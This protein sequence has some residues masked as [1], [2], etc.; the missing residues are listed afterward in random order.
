MESTTIIPIKVGDITSIIEKY[1]QTPD[2]IY[3]NNLLKAIP[4]LKQLI[5]NDKELRNSCSITTEMPIKL[6]NYTISSR[7]WECAQLAISKTIKGE[8]DYV[9]H[10][11]ID[12]VNDFTRAEKCRRTGISVYNRQL[13]IDEINLLYMTI[14]LIEQCIG[15][16]TTK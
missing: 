12:I 8:Y 13:S 1:M 16:N 2:D 6:T 5:T 10:E 14:V 11:I 3:S 7:Q 9:M 4:E 15:S